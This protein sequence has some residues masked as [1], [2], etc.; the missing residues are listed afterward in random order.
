MPVTLAKSTDTA[1]HDEAVTL[2]ITV[3]VTPDGRV[4]DVR[5]S[6]TRPDEHDTFIYGP[7]RTVWQLPVP[8]WQSPLPEFDEPCYAVKVLDLAISSDYRE[9]DAAAWAKG[10]QEQREFFKDTDGSLTLLRNVA[11]LLNGNGVSEAH[12]TTVCAQ[13]YGI[14]IPDPCDD[15]Y[16]FRWPDGWHFALQ[17]TYDD[18]GWILWDGAIAPFDATPAQVVDAAMAVLAEYDN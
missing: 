14:T 18:S 15:R 16:L 3:D 6:D 4:D 12:I 13:E 11:R 10:E 17:C 7:R 5:M 9:D 2:Y 8:V 1:P